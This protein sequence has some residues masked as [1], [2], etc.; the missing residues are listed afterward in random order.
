MSFVRNGRAGAFLG[1]PSDNDIPKKRL[2]GGRGMCPSTLSFYSYCN[3]DNHK[4]PRL[5]F[6]HGRTIS[7]EGGGPASTSPRDYATKR[8][9]PKVC[10]HYH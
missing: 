9:K 4:S 7:P 8:Q 6:R 10:D 2:A 5:G 1:M 3:R